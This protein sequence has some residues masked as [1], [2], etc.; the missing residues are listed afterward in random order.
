MMPGGKKPLVWLAEA[1]DLWLTTLMLCLTAEL[2]VATQC[3]YT[4]RWPLYAGVAVYMGFAIAYMR[5]YV[6]D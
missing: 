6:L 2:G 3:R 5:A 1:G 4:E